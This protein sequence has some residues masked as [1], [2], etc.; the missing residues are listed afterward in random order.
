LSERGRPKAVPSEVQSARQNAGNENPGG[1]AC[2]ADGR[3]VW[4]VTQSACHR[5]VS[6]RTGEKP[7]YLRAGH[8][9]G[10]QYSDPSHEA[11]MSGRTRRRTRGTKRA[12]RAHK[13]R[14]VKR[15]LSLKMARRRVLFS[16]G[17]W[18]WEQGTSLRA[19]AFL[20]S[21][22]ERPWQNVRACKHGRES[23]RPGLQ[24]TEREVQ[25]L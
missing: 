7:A 6:D 25:G 16:Q 23:T 2:Q 11:R 19:Q 9:G 4:R 5:N 3:A 21:A 18:R 10:Y 8:G 20:S 1:A 24:W 17:E 22:E 14:K 15:N 13:K 12:Q